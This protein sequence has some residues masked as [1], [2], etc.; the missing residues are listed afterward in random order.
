MINLFDFG[1]FDVKYKMNLKILLRRL[2]HEANDMGFEPASLQVA[3][4]TAVVYNTLSA[5]GTRSRL[6]GA[7]VLIKQARFNI[8][9]LPSESK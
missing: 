5:V 1:F 7:S 8:E 3:G 9:P 4:R 6:Y 2:C